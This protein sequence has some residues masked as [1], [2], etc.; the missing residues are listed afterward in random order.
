MFIYYIALVSFGFLA[1]IVFL[2]L[3]KKINSKYGLLNLRG[4]SPLGGLSMGLSFT[5][6][7]LLTSFAYGRALPGAIH[8]IIA[9]FFMLIFGVIDDLRELSIAAKFL[10]QIIAT[11]LL[12]YFGIRT[13]IVYIGT[14]ANIIITFIWV[15]GI[16]NAFN[17]LD[18]M[19]G[20]AAG[21]SAMIS[22]TFFSVSFLNKDVNNAILSLVLF[23]VCLSYFLYNFPPAKIYMGNAGSHF[24]GFVFA[25]VAIAISYAPPERKIA[26]ASP[27]LILGLPIFDTIFLI[28]VRVRKGRLPFRKS[29]DH[30]ALRLL[31]MGYSKQKA[32]FC[33]LALNLLFCVSGIALS[34]VS[35]ITGLSIILTVIIASLLVAKKMDRATIDG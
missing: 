28:L 2:M 9:S 13:R 21:T 4:V 31:E 17:H 25:A 20:L 5:T 30:L 6:V 19:D 14:V 3:L 11:C 7:C 29:N 10:M 12:V 26:L 32:L 34:R 16:T 33:I 8:I 15:I 18:I 1:H 24:L 27:L 23:A 22:L 35:N